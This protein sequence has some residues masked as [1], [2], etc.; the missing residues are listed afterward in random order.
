MH[1]YI[2]I[3]ENWQDTMNVNFYFGGNSSKIFCTLFLLYFFTAIYLPDT[4]FHLHLP[5]HPHDHTPHESTFL[6][7][8]NT[9]KQI[10]S[11]TIHTTSSS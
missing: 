5:C 11:Y 7:F 3:V 8:I 1:F 4:I 9:A 6:D 10:S 2:Y